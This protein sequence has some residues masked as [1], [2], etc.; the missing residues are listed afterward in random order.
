M[1]N[2]NIVKCLLKHNVLITTRTV[3]SKRNV[4][5][6]SHCFSLSPSLFPPKPISLSLHKTFVLSVI[7]LQN[8]IAHVIK[9]K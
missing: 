2:I 4:D 9:S 3:K 8:V 1:F 7:N 6:T 5:A